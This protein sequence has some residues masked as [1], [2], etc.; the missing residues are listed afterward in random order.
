MKIDLNF[1]FKGIDDKELPT[2]NEKGD[3]LESNHAGKVTGQALWFYSSG[4]SLKF[5]EWGRKLYKELP[6]ELDSTDYDVFLAW[7]ETYGQ[8]P[9]YKGSVVTVL[10]I[11][12]FREQV[13]KALKDQKEK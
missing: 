6:I 9:N 7:L 13:I 12:G 11:D 4:K 3:K 2:V 10:Q 8:D 1:Q 5:A